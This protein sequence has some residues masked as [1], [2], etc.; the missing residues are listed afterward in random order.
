MEKAESRFEEDKIS[1]WNEETDKDELKEDAEMI[2]RE[3]EGVEY[4]PPE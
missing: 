4:I 2:S 1:E 3:M